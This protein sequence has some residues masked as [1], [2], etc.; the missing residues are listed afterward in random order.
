[1]NKAECLQYFFG[2][3]VTSENQAH[4]FVVAWTVGTALGLGIVAIS[5]ILAFA[6]EW[7]SKKKLGGGI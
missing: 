5:A 3:C 1:M 7:R 2:M 4:N 6:G